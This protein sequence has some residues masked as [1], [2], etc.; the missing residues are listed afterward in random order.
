MDDMI[1]LF[2]NFNPSSRFFLVSFKNDVHHHRRG[3]NS[4]LKDMIRSATEQ[5]NEIDFGLIFM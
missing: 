1:T 2:D 4:S 3:S 5:L